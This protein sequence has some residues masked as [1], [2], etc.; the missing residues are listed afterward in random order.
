MVEDAGDKLSD[1]DKE[2]INQAVEKAKKVL[3]DQS[4]EKKTFEEVAES[5]SQTLQEIGA[6]L[7]QAGAQEPEKKKEEVEPEGD[8]DAEEGEIVD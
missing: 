4:A 2:K 7:H 1:E 3:T 8:E 5:L 6:K